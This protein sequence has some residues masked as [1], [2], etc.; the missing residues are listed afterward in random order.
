M[1]QG[2]EISKTTGVEDTTCMTLKHSNPAPEMV[3]ALTGVDGPLA[4][5]AQPKVGGMS[6]A[7]EK[8]VLEAINGESVTKIKRRKKEKEAEAEE[9]TP[10]TKQQETLDQKDEVLKAATEARKYALTLKNLSYSGELVQGLMAFSTKMEGIYE[11]ISTLWGEGCK[12]EKRWDNILNSIAAQM[13]WYA[14]AQAHDRAFTFHT[15]F[16][17]MCFSNTAILLSKHSTC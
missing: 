15:E 7:G 6:E 16:S 5:G 1:A 3:A 11:K 4:S 9:L 13:K 14:Q 17:H 8:N 2:G 10:K 12:D